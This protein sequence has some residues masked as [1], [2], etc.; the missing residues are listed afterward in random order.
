MTRLLTA[1]LAAVGLIV[2]AQPAAAQV[3]TTGSIEVVVVDQ[4]GARLP[5]VLVTASASDTVTRRT[6]VTNNEGVATLEALAPSARYNIETELTGFSAVKQ[7]QLLVRSGQTTSVR[8]TLAL[9]TLTEEVQ[10]T[11]ESPVS[12]SRRA[13][14]GQDITLRADRVAAHRPQLSELPAARAGRAARRSAE[15]PAI[16]PL[17]PG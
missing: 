2:L 9:A 5:G 3:A 8:I 4:S 10:V 16:R 12:T 14:T 1:A 6:A 11:A 15:S 7:E 17:A 13:V